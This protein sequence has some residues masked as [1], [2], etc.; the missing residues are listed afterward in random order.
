MI[1]SSLLLNN[2]FIGF[3]KH[4]RDLDDHIKTEKTLAHLEVAASSVT[5]TGDSRGARHA[6]MTSLGSM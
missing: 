4:S 1:S 3:E 6:S 2:V 5:Q